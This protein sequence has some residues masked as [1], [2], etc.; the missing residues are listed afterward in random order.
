MTYLCSGLAK[1][2][3]VVLANAI[4]HAWLYPSPPPPP[5]LEGKREGEVEE[6]GRLT[7]KGSRD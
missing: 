3:M 6:E 1:G 4:N 5:W 2:V 7:E